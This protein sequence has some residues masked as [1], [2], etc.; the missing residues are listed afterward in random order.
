M[1]TWIYV[2][3]FSLR[4]NWY[5]VLSLFI[6]QLYISLGSLAEKV[7]SDIELA[8]LYETGKRFFVRKPKLDDGIDKDPRLE[9][10]TSTTYLGMDALV[11]QTHACIMNGSSVTSRVVFS[12][13]I[14]ILLVLTL[15]IMCL[16]SNCCCAQDF[17]YDPTADKQT[18]DRLIRWWQETRTNAKHV[19][20]QMSVHSNVNISDFSDTF[21]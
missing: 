2:I 11:R 12:I 10:N 17:L 18:M 19:V 9:S 21:F 14:P 16:I 1:V 3:Q 7:I 20:Q 4:V 13:T 5:S 6:L 15:I 8:R